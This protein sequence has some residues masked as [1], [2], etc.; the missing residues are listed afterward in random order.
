[1][2]P[3]RYVSNEKMWYV[4]TPSPIGDLTLVSDGEMLIGLYMEGREDDALRR[5]GRNGARGGPACL[6]TSAEQLAAYFAGEL[7][8]F[9][10]PLAF[11]GTGFQQ[12][13]WRELQRIPF[14]TTIS[15]SELALRIGKPAAVRAVGAANGRNPIAIVVPCHRVIGANGSL[16]G[17]GGGLD[18]KRWLLRHEAHADDAGTAPLVRGD[19]QAMPRAAQIGMFELAASAR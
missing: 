4:V 14:A 3:V 19:R 13:C 15:Y 1:V 9:D 10:L 7:R 17:F 12:D 11:H 6:R 18:R 5:D 8:T 16:V 2:T